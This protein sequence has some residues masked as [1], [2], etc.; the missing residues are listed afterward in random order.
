MKDIEEKRLL[1]Q[2]NE[3][4]QE[5]VKVGRQESIENAILWLTEH[6]RM[7]VICESDINDLIYD[8]TKAMEE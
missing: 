1:Y 5:G 3:A 7:Y 2:G 4:F 8:F 6:G